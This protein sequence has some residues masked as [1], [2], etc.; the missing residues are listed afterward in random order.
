MTYVIAIL[1]LVVILFGIVL[2]N[3][4]KKIPD[5]IHSKNLEAFKSELQKEVEKLKISEGNLHI[6]KIEKFSEF[7]EILNLAM[8]GIKE[9]KDPKLLAEELNEAMNKFAKDVMFFA[10]EGTLKKFVEYKRYSDIVQKGGDNEKAKYQ[11]LIAELIL[12]MRK[13][14]GYSDDGL[15]VDHYMY[16]TVQNWGNH[17]ELYHERAKMAIKLNE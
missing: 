8:T 17:R 13:D 16:I 2:Y 9:K 5:Q 6:R 15:N 10:S 3:F 1:Q 7:I 4:I 12:E 11:F 14:L